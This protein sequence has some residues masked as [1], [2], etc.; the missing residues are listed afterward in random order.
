[1]NQ[2]CLSGMR[3]RIASPLLQFLMVSLFVAVLAGCSNRLGPAKASDLVTLIS[4]SSTPICPATTTPHIFGDRLLPDGSRVPFTIPDGQVLVV[5]SYDWMVT[6]STYA[7]NTMWT[8]LVVTTPKAKNGN[9]VFFSG[10][11]ADSIGT[12][13]GSTAIPEGVAVAPG[14]SLCMDT[15]GGTSSAYGHLHGYLVANR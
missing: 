8:A 15:L 12:A 6:G 14:A 4:D 10:A 11:A 1:M 2:G 9:L 13:T 3:G 5:T 7:K